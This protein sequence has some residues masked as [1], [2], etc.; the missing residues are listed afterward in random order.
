LFED[1]PT[2]RLLDADFGEAGIGRLDLTSGRCFE[3]TSVSEAL[4]H[5]FAAAVALPL[6]AAVGDPLDL[7]RRGL[8][9]DLQAEVSARAAII[10]NLAAET[11][12][13]EQRATEASARA[14]LTEKEAEAVDA[15]L[16]RLEDA[17]GRT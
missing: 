12:G 11:H 5:E 17:P 10:E 9:G 13:A 6:R 2:Y 4:V 3:S 15:L 8:L 16:V 14:G 1:R 7:R